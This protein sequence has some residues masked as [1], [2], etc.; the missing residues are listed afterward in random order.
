[1][2]VENTLTEDE[3]ENSS[4]RVWLSLIHFPDDSKVQLSKT[5]RSFIFQSAPHNI[6][7]LIGR[8]NWNR[9]RSNVAVP[10]PLGTIR[11]LL[12]NNEKDLFIASFSVTKIGSQK[13][14]IPIRLPY[15]VVESPLFKILALMCLTRNVFSTGNFQT[16]NEAKATAIIETFELVFGVQL[17]KGENKRGAYIR[18]P[19]QLVQA[20]NLFFTNETNS[21]IEIL[22]ESLK[23]YPQEDILT[24]INTWFTYYRI[25]R[26]PKQSK[27]LFIFRK[28]DI[29][30]PIAR[31]MEKCNI[32]MDPGTI[33]ESGQI[34]PV[35]VVKN[36]A[37]NLLL[38]D[39]PFLENQSDSRALLNRITNLRS[40]IKA[41]DET[42]AVL[43]DLTE[44]LNLELVEQH[45]SMLTTSYSQYYYETK[46][47]KLEENFSE[48][49]RI[50]I[51]L[52]KENINLKM[53]M[54]QDDPTRL[55]KEFTKKS[56][57]QSP[58]IEKITRKTLEI[59]VQEIK[60]SKNFNNQSLEEFVEYVEREK[61]TEQ[62]QL[63]LKVRGEED[64][65]M[66][67]SFIKSN[68][69]NP[70]LTSQLIQSLSFLMI[71]KE[72]LLL[73]ALADGKPRTEFEIRE[74]LQLGF[75]ESRRLL[76]T[77]M[78]DL[79][80]EPQR[81][82]NGEMAYQINPD[83][84]KELRIELKRTINQLPTDIRS[85]WKALFQF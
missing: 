1:M 58:D 35:Y 79:K 12:N 9:Y 53:L 85:Q 18:I 80:L 46:T 3:D 63:R 41:K 27:Q 42:I 56:K 69:T 26:N 50:R 38:L 71:R 31:L 19:L 73:L 60:S 36:S 48:L 33:Q 5:G 17:T 65:T 67:S 10:I 15:K 77:I 82:K 68:L 59:V 43:E 39:L 64:E 57:F 54:S 74:I 22:I 6:I 76:A 45:R 61:S 23:N 34:V 70:A 25:Y 52:E 14:Q 2:E 24:F 47:K 51:G 29:T 21:K 4:F 72:N 84:I 16:D 20:I 7:S 44:K 8:A 49:H 75:A 78:D 83:T 37:Q 66:S 13:L 40:Q 28:Q 55:P 32:E 11:S 62:P 30:K 81:Q